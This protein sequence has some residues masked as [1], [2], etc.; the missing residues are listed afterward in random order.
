MFENERIISAYLY[1]YARMLVADIPDE[2][3]TIQPSGIVNHPAWTLGH[4]ANTADAA[5]K[6]LGVAPLCPSDWPEKFGR[7]STPL[8]DRGIYPAKGVL[9]AALEAAHGKLAAAVESATPEMLNAAN[10]NERN[11]QFFPT[12][13]SLIAHIMTSHQ[14]THL[15]QLSAWRRAMG[16]KSVM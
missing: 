3:M 15:G 10:P 12:A 5:L 16:M 1:G 9:M 13:G 8:P 2:Q 4:L 7:G 6:L 11:R 14:A